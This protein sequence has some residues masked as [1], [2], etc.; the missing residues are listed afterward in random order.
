MKDIF[1]HTGEGYI[2]TGVKIIIAI[3]IGALLIGGL[4][5]IFNNETGIMSEVD[6][7]VKEMMDYGSD[8]GY[9][10][11]E[12]SEYITLSDISYTQ[13]GNRWH[14]VNIEGYSED[15]EVKF[16]ASHEK[17]AA[18]MLLEGD[19]SYLLSTPDG[20]TWTKHKAYTDVRYDKSTYLKWY[21]GED[22]SYFAVLFRKGDWGYTW[23]STDCINWRSPNAGIQ[24]FD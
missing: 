7:E 6:N 11:I 2:D 21:E 24:F 20:E 8:N 14:K 22:G 17:M 1:N 12:N 10:R 18:L 4:Y 19:T 23:K 16:F 5:L 15:A 13:G 9:Y 3:V